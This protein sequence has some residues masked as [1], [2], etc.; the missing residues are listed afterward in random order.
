MHAIK[1]LG[2]HLKTF[3][4]YA[5]ISWGEADDSF[6]VFAEE[7]RIG[8]VQLF[9][10][11][12]DRFVAVHELHL[13]AGDERTVYPFLGCDTAGLADDGAKITFSQAETVGVVAYLVLLGA[14]QVDK[15]DETVEDGLFA[16]L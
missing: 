4:R 1:F 11:L 3:A 2:H 15:L 5:I 12:G 10:D 6:E 9:S 16:R 14:M 7:R 13:D 8:E